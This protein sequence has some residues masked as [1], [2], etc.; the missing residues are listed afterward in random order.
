MNTNIPTPYKADILVVDDKPD[1]L[2]LLSTMLTEQGYKVRKVISGELALKACQIMPPDLILLDINMPNMNGYM[3]CQHL[4]SKPE[5]QNIPVIFISALDGVVDKVEA[6]SHGGADYITKPF[7]IQEVLAR[8]KN[9]LTIRQLQKKL[10]QQNDLL[11]QE[12]KERERAETELQKLNRELHLLATLDGLTQ[13]GNRRC[14]DENFNIEWRRLQREKAPLSL[15]LCDVDYF[16]LY[17]DTYGHLVGDFCLKQIAQ[18]INHTLKRPA[19]LVA[20]YGGEEFAII[21]PHTYIEG[22]VHIAELVQQNIQELQIVHGK[23]SVAEY[24]TLSMGVSC[25]I[26]QLNL[27]PNQLIDATDEALYAAKAQGRNCVVAKVLEIPA[28]SS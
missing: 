13:V 11:S 16:K 23:S 5:T 27:A 15:I 6:F 4:K 24:V 21:L 17:N 20:R 26:P 7:E 1:N 28:E 12:I 18:T 8:V 2:R 3:V 10:Q 19:D 22:A 25:V 14:F 9:Q